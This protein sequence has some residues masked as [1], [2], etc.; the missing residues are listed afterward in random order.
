MITIWTRF[1]AG[2]LATIPYPLHVC[3][4]LR[5]PQTRTLVKVTICR[6]TCTDWGCWVC[7]WSA[8]QFIR[9][10][11]AVPFSI[12]LP[13]LV[14]AQVI[15]LAVKLVTGTTGGARGRWRC[16]TLKVRFRSLILATDNTFQRCTLNNLPRLCDLAIKVK[17]SCRN[18]VI[19]A[20]PTSMS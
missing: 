6:V 15:R 18:E 17:M 1:P 3:K 11:C 16:T 20:L 12:T 2:C 19:G 13:I 9:T 8:L 4:G 10:I 5:L 14:D 7:F